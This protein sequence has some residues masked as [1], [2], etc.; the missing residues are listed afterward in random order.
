MAEGEITMAD[1]MFTGF[2]SIREARA[3]VIAIDH[4]NDSAIEVIEVM[5]TYVL[6]TDEDQDYDRE[7]NLTEAL[8]TPV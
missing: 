1:I 3:F 4:V 5:P 6:I 8:R 2:E 7:I